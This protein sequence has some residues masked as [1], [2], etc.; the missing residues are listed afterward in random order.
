M[1]GLLGAIA[2]FETHHAVP[3]FRA[4]TFGC[5]FLMIAA[6]A[7]LARARARDG[8]LV[9]SALA[10]GLCVLEAAATP[11]KPKRNVRT[12]PFWLT[13][14]PEVGFAFTRAG[15]IHA[16][17]REPGTGAVVFDATYTIGPTFDRVVRSRDT[18]PAVVFFGDSFTF[19]EG[20]NDAETLPQV[21]ADLRGGKERVL[22]LAV[23]GYSP[24]QFLRE[25]QIGLRDDVIGPRPGV[26][27]FLTS[28]F[29]AKR[30]ACKESWTNYAPRFTLIDDKVV[31]QG[32]CF[33]GFALGF[34]EFLENSALYQLTAQPFLTKLT[35][36]D[37]DLYIR[38]L[39]D[40]VRL[41]RERY[42]VETLV[43]YVQAGS[44]YLA[45]TGYTEG[46]IMDALRAR[47][48]R[49]VDMTLHDDVA[50]GLNYS[51][52][53]DGHPTAAANVVRARM[54]AD[55]LKDVLPPAQPTP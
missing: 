34:H 28:S 20:V 18:G 41:S 35:R 13:I 19:G 38:I 31:H 5:M 48:V 54:I 2:W 43:P 42:G 10:F 47:G 7:T 23:T 40:A 9:C 27:V 49:V 24:Q 1:L 12:T 14:A 37:I 21:F 6:G 51:I 26:F 52:H 39:A 3:G 45:G 4:W 50:K 29:H 44:D 36:A 32:A 53:G 8:L 15:V 11:L 25:V 33:S 55:A 30:T 16:L 46:E 17:E 22:N